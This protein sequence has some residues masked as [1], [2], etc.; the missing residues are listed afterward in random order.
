M[1]FKVLHSSKLNAEKW[2][3][4]ANKYQMDIYSTF[5][6]LNAVCLSDWY[7]FVWGDYE[8]ILPFYRKKK[9]GIFSYICMPPFCQKFDNSPLTLEEWEEAILYLKGRNVKID[10]SV[11]DRKE[12]SECVERFNFVLD[13]RSLDIEAVRSQFSSLLKKNIEKAGLSLDVKSIVEERD[14]E[15]LYS[16][17][18]SFQSL[19]LKK[20]ALQFENLTHTQLSGVY[21]LN[22]DGKE[23]IAMLLY[24]KHG[25]KIYLLF[26]YT[27]EEGKK[28]QAMS[29]LIDTLIDNKEI[30]V[31]DFE[32][33]S[34]DSIA[35][36]YSQF[37][38][39][40]QSYWAIHWKSRFFPI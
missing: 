23:L 29:L 17:L 7:C 15:N 35:N 37:N 20:F 36:F 33:S 6:Y 28:K 32:G 9:W 40:K 3:Q 10:Y 26:P 2:N 27:A 21:A 13:K 30:E 12:T 22:K 34:I 39:E 1:N 11:V 8:K 16:K 4:C 38:A 19:V 14:L 24:A 5:E 25:K 31:V 18:P